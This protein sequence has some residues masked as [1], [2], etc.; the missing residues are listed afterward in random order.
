[1]AHIE[2]GHK[3]EL[4]KELL[5]CTASSKVLMT[6]F[7]LM[8]ILMTFSTLFHLHFHPILLLM[9]SLKLDFILNNL[10]DH[11]HLIDQEDN[12]SQK[13]KSVS[14]LQAKLAKINWAILEKT[15]SNSSHSREITLE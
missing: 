7:L 10:L 5:I 12:F 6:V 15:N 11:L 1:L 4:L 2:I 13:N 14:K 9:N 3:L 8:K